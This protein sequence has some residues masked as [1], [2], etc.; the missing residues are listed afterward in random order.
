MGK[1]NKKRTI[2]SKETPLA[3]MNFINTLG[4]IK[5]G[6]Q[7]MVG[8]GE[9]FLKGMD[10]FGVTKHVHFYHKVLLSLQSVKYDD[11]KKTISKE[12]RDKTIELIKK[13]KLPFFIE[14]NLRSLVVAN[15]RNFLK[16]YSNPQP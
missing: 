2:P 4:D 9:H 7:A 8:L 10:Y 16:D 1:P 11:I 3:Y 5:P 15:H 12:Y 6:Q 13:Y 14:R